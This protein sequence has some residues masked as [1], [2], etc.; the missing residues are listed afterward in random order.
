MF[1]QN[2][3]FLSG[4]VIDAGTGMPLKNASITLKGSLSGTLSDSTGAFSL[5]TSRNI[6]FLNV[7]IL[8]YEKTSVRVNRAFEDTVIVALT[9]KINTLDEVVINALPVQ[10]VSKS[11]RYNVLDYDFYKDNV[12]MITYVDLD[13]AKL[14]LINENSDT[15]GYKKIPSEPN[16]LFRDCLGNLHVVCKDSIY[17]AYY[18]GNTLSLLPAKSVRDFES[19]LLPCVAQDSSSLIL[20]R[21]FGS[22]R[23]EA[24]EF[25]PFFT[26]NLAIGY[27]C[28]DKKNRKRKPLIYIEDEKTIVMSNDEDYYI[29]M[30]QRA[31]LKTF[32]DRTFSETLI[33][34][35]IYSPLYTIKNRIYLFDYAN[36]Y[37]KT[38]DK[39]NKVKDAIPINFHNTIQ[40]SRAMDVDRK[41]NKAFAFFESDGLTEVKE[42]N[43][44][45][46]VI[47][48]SY[49]IPFVFVTQVKVNNDYI[50]FI[51]KGKND[52]DTRYL[53]RMKMN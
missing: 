12:L 20:E 16:R 45:T 33:F 17:Q 10:V 7:S 6:V 1:S 11:R 27:Y 50:Y 3:P 35:E 31:G 21:R 25:H 5:E 30:K 26:H 37:I 4:W 13:R 46:G 8:G 18:D 32:G 40:F 47:T 38:F 53:S 15:L 22:R 28:I 24:D 51:R 23:M 48:T 14:V 49:K 39:E 43:L 41:T 19:I 42:I 44:N 9:R 34:K 52:D 29:M 36:G 2:L